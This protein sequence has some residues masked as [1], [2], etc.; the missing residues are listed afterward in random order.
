MYILEG[1]LLIS[2]FQIHLILVMCTSTFCEIVCEFYYTK[3]RPI[4]S[5][6]RSLPHLDCKVYIFFQS[7]E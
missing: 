5:V 7:L 2:D 4:E 1:S 6:V 3:D